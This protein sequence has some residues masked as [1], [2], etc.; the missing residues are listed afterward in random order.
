MAEK[1]I[2]N[3]HNRILISQIAFWLMV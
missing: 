3:K 1:Q 2:L